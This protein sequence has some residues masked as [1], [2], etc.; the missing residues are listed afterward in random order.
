MKHWFHTAILSVAFLCSKLIVAQAGQCLGGGCGQ[1]GNGF[2]YPTGTITNNTA[3]WITVADNIWYGEWARYNVIAGNTYEWSLCA[4]D[5]AFSPLDMQLTLRRDDN[6]ALLC[7][8]DDVCGTNPKI[9]WT[10][11]FTGVVRVQTNEFNCASYF[12]FSLFDLTLRFRCSSCVA[13]AVSGCI[14]PAP[15]CTN[16]PYNFPNSTNILPGLG[17]VICLSTT[18]NPVWYYMEI[19]QPGNL[20]ININQ[21]TNF[22]F[23]IDV[24]YAL[25]GPFNS[26]AEGCAAIGSGTATNIDVSCSYSPSASEQAVINNAQ[27]GEVY[28]LLLTNFSNQ[29]G[30]IQFSAAPG[31]TATTNCDI[32]VVNCPQ[33]ANAVSSPL[34]TCGN[35]PYYLKVTNTQCNG[36]IYF[37]VVGNFGSAWANEITWQVVSL[38]TNQVV[39]SGGPGVNG[40]SFSSLVGPLNPSITG[41]IFQLIVNDAFGDGFNG[42]G[43]FIQVQQ[44]SNII[45]GPITGN[46]GLQSTNIFGV[47]I[48]ISSATITVQTPSGPVSSTQ[49]FCRDFRVP[50][51]I[52]HNNFCSNTN[53]SLPWTIVCDA[54]D[55]IIASGT[56]NLTI[57]PAIPTQASDVV[58]ISWNSSNCQW[59]VEG[60]NDCGA[61][62]IGNLFNIEPNP[63]TLPQ[64]CSAG[65]QNFQVN[66][67][68]NASG[69]N[70]CS[71][72]GPM[73]PV[74]LNQTYNLSNFIRSGTPFGGSNNAALLQIPG[75]GVGGFANSLNLNFSFTGYCYPTNPNPFWVTVIMDGIIIYDQMSAMTAPTSFNLNLNLSAFPGYNQNSVIEVYIYPNNLGATYN[76]GASCAS[77]NA[78]NWTLNSATVSINATY[79]ELTTSP[80]DC[81]LTFTAN[82]TCC[83]PIIVSNIGETIC[84]GQSINLLSGWQNAVNSANTN[85]VVFSSVVPV[86]GSVTPDNQFPNGINNG[87]TPITQT[88]SAY[89]YCD[90]DGSGTVNAGDTYTLI[91]T[92]TLTINPLP[93]AGIGSD[94]SICGSGNEINLFSLLGGSPQGGGIWT[95]PSMLSNGSLGTFNPG[96][97]A[98]G[99]YT[100]TITGISPCGSAAATIEVQV[101]DNTEAQINYPGP[102]CIDINTPQ[103]PIINGAGGGTFSATPAGL[104]INSTTG[105]IIPSLSTP[106]T[107]TVTYSIPASGSCPAFST[108]ETVVITA[109]PADP[110]LNPDPACAGTPLIFTAGNGVLYEFFLNE[111]SQGEVSNQNT[112][113][114]GSLNAGDEVCVRSYPPVPFVINGLIN[115]SQWGNP[116]AKS[117]GGPVSGFGPNNNLD[118]IY[119]KNMNGY[120]YGAVA[121]RVE[122]N[123]NNRILVFIDS[124]P[125]GFNNLGAWTNR[126][127]VPYV[128]IENLNGGITF[129]PGFEPDYIL[130]MNEANNEAYFDLYDMVNNTNLY[131]G[132]NLTLFAPNTQLAYQANTGQFDF[133]RGFEFSFPLSF[134]SNPSNNMK[135]FAMIVNDPGLGN[136]V[137]TFLSNQFLTP[138]NFG[139]NNYGDGAVFFEFAAPDPI[140][141]NLSADCYSETCIT[142]QPTVAPVTGFAL[143]AEVCQDDPNVI[144]S[145]T[146]GF[147]PGGTFSAMPASGLA[148]NPSTGAID[149]AASVPNTYNI[150]Y[151]VPANGCNP[152]GTTTVS[153]TINPTPTTTTIYHD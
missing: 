143:P 40:A 64:N 73:V 141:F 67:I 104:N 63:A 16:I 91:S 74:V 34:E 137:A 28:I 100:Y 29:A 110:I 127:N 45:V 102:Y 43:G 77:M 130:A 68:G 123:S 46:F 18:P 82:K 70:C 65:Q 53:I 13:P 30:N 134:L 87:I 24:D 55:A 96:S 47:N 105:A 122:N 52:N 119:L 136:P 69:P 146:G 144:P 117:S 19:D 49:E 149:V 51:Q 88:V 33:Y 121:G 27:A 44:G 76:P 106:G 25:W 98:P 86:A 58:N 92:Y 11:T 132:S 56:T 120:L 42:V 3:N 26:V 118:A 71:T 89:T 22:G 126:S 147:T 138:A 17:P 99:T 48:T 21:F 148:I 41:N 101:N 150:T 112:F 36:E 111:V 97:N 4:T 94:I 139:E 35:Q 59:V 114:A 85:C 62:A 15:F 95:G 90:V 5:G 113:N 75:T 93:N 80:A 115:E 133:T 14:D 145:L 153:I 83:P 140:T 128:S 38:L 72:G 37:N 60:A 84:A 57:Y 78:S 6:L 125:G 151:T 131:L 1:N 20:T 116:L 12:L 109:I 108:T 103:Q 129:D 61:A 135:V 107:Y 79:T 8:S 7:Y 66:Y 50:I 152:A 10:A 81:D 9:T 23:P 54:T 39:A 31:S 142:V 124:R 32:V 2:L